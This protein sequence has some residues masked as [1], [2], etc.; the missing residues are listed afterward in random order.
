MQWK[1]PLYSSVKRALISTSGHALATFRQPRNETKR[2]SHAGRDVGHCA[3]AGKTW[4]IA[5]TST[6]TT[7]WAPHSTSL[8]PRAPHST[9]HD[10]GGGSDSTFNDTPSGGATMS[11]TTPPTTATTAAAARLRHENMEPDA[12]E[13]GA[14]AHAQQELS[15]QRARGRK[16]EDQCTD[17]WHCIDVQRLP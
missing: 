7:A 13:A 17:P 10:G 12:R 9:L 2:N 16:S 15:A 3:V 8:P 5:S 14:Q 4:Q 6:G 1:E 11:M